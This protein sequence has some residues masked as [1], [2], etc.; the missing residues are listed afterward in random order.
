[1][2]L[3]AVCLD[4]AH[5][6]S[7]H[8]PVRYL[9]IFFRIVSLLLEQSYVWPQ[10]GWSWPERK[11]YIQ[12]GLFCKDLGNFIHT[13]YVIQLHSYAVNWS[14]CLAKS[15]NWKIVFLLLYY[16]NTGVQHQPTQRP[17]YSRL[18]N[19]CHHWGRD[20]W[21]PLHKRHFKHIFWN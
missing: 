12:T 8:I 7:W 4:V 16:D 18:D 1:M 13:K 14:D 5:D 20:K 11:E 15:S 3:N 6:S 19:L 21:P 2:L 10:C 17:T 9:R